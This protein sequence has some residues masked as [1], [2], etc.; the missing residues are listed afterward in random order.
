MVELCNPCVVSPDSKGFCLSVP[1]RETPMASSTPGLKKVGTF[2]HYSLM[3]GGK[4]IHG[5]TRATDLATARRILEEK[6]R[7]LLDGTL[8]RSK[9]NITARELIQEWFQVN[10][11]TFSRGHLVSAECAIRLWVLPSIGTLPVSQVTTQ[12]VLDL[13]RKILGAGRSSTYANNILRTLK[14][15]F[16]HGVKLRY[17]TNLPFEVTRLRVQQKPRVIVPASRVQ[18]LFSAVDRS[19]RNHH[20]PVM[21]RVMVGLGLRESEVLGMRWEWLEPEQK[22]YC[23]GKAKGKEARVLPVPIWLWKSI[24]SMPKTQSEWVFPAKDGKPHRP[25]FCKKALQRVCE[26]LG[27]GNVTQHRLRATFAS[28]HALAGSPITEIQGMLGH[29]SVQT[30]QIYVERSLD[31]KRIAQDTL[32]QKLGLS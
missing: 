1:L 7:E 27:L 29:K 16:N 32:S 8:L 25:Q 20:I 13:R 11:A 30:T 22:C 5:S 24:H 10:D 26:T 14:A 2:W 31:A 15:I 4:R 21:I 12:V 9:K 28:L 19:A 17:L 18:E 23:V 3:V 6:R